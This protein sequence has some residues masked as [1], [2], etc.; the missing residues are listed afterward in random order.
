MLQILPLLDTSNVQIAQNFFNVIK[1]AADMMNTRLIIRGESPEQS[2]AL[3]VKP[4]TIEED[5]LLTQQFSQELRNKED[6]LIKGEDW[7][8]FMPILSPFD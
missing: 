3:A 4:R 5:E 6:N 2:S 8:I 7:R 1:T